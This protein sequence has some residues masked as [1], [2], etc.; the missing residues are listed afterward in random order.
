MYATWFRGAGAEYVRLSEESYASG[1]PILHT[2]G[3][4]IVELAGDRAIAQTRMT[5]SLRAPVHDIP[6]DVV[7]T[8]RFYD[9]F[10]K[11][12]GRWAISLR[13]PIY[14]LSRI[15]PVDPT[16]E[17]KLDRARLERFPPGYRHIAYVQSLAGVDVAQ[18]MPGTHGPEVESL[19]A[20]GAAWLRGEALRR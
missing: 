16:A 19:Y 8:G 11:R 12:N 14:E 6:C 10:E 4:T 5:I 2:L 20:E 3:G 13:Y 7:I 1:P 15:N 17:L 18:G 9:F